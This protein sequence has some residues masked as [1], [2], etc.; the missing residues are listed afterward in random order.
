MN[1][2]MDWPGQCRALAEPVAL[3]CAASPVGAGPAVLARELAARLPQ[4]S[5]REVLCRGGWYRIGGV[6][7]ASGERI[8]QSAEEW[9]AEAL[10][11]RDGDLAALWEDFAGSGLR[12]TRHSGRTHFLVAPAGEAP[13]DFLQLEIEE[14][15]EVVGEPLFAGAEPPASLEQLV[16]PRAHGG[17][18]TPLGQPWYALRRLVHVGE[19][20]ARARGPKAGRSGADRFLEDWAASSA[21]RATLLCNHWVVAIREHLDRYRQKIVQA[22][23]LPAL[24][25][26]PAP[27][28]AC[29]GTRGLALQEAMSAFDRRLGHPFAWYFHMLGTR[30]VPFWVA[31]QIAEDAREGYAYLPER[32]LAVLRRWLHDPYAL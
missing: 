4:W 13:G 25:G 11:Q 12:M 15:Q 20:L 27:L 17:A 29:E 7:E 23:P 31:R 32:D 22:R 30:A 1:A 26:D 2:P 10:S 18:R 24:Q 3:A 21:Q 28:A 5:F 14:L 9:A 16:D 19:L 8:A 6:V